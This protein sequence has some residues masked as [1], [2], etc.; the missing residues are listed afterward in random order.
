MLRI[1]CVEIV[2]F[3]VFGFSSLYSAQAAE[4]LPNVLI[5]YGLEHTAMYPA[6]NDLY[7]YDNSI[8]YWGYF[9]PSKEYSYKSGKFTP[10]GWTS[11]NAVG[12]SDHYTSNTDNW[13][14]NFLNWVSMTHADLIRK[15][16][17]GGKRVS[18]ANSK[19]I[20]IREDVR[21]DHAFRKRYSGADLRNLVPDAFA[22]SE[23]YFVTS[24]TTLTIQN[25]S[26]IALGRGLDVKV[27]VCD[28]TMPEVNC[29]LYPSWRMKPEG[30]VQRYHNKFN[31][32]L[33]SHSFSQMTEGGILRVPLGSVSDEF[34]LKSGQIGSSRGVINFIN[35]VDIS[36]GWSPTAELYYE[37]LRYLKGN[38]AGQEAYC[39][40][41]GMKSE[42]GFDVIGCDSRSMWVD[43]ITDPCQKN[44]ILILTDEYPSK[45]TN[46]LPGSSISPGYVDTPMNF[47]MNIPYN[48][49]VGGVTDQIG[50]LEGITGGGYAIGNIVGYADNKCT[51]K[52]I[53][54]LSEAYGICPSEPVA[55]GSF[56]TAALAFD[57][58][59]G[60]IRPDL[61]GRQNAETYVIAYRGSP[62]GY[63]YPIPPLNPLWLTGKYGNFR[64]LDY[65]LVPDDNNEWMKAAEACNPDDPTDFYC[66]PRGL[67]YA[68]RGSAIEDAIVPF[69]RRDIGEDGICDNVGDSDNDGVVDQDDRCPFDPL[70]DTDGDSMCA[71]IDPC[72]NDSANDAD[73][74]GICGDVDVCPDFNDTIDADADGIPDACDNCPNHYNP[75]QEDVNSDGVGDVCAV[76]AQ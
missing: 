17:T 67:F 38:E 13:S 10:E 45:D 54:N 69:L 7:N 21:P 44:I 42:S 65:N 50:L 52:M 29:T 53:I 70:N 73:Q 49:D 46:T 16:M 4:P 58:F 68:E 74:D 63:Q 27:T 1:L 18:D 60:D 37:A 24:G 31:F 11:L 47:G 41:V 75:A 61:P 57:A 26:G 59:T 32:G 36:R 39:G 35:E 19:T 5:L 48:P 55:E 20:L 76:I 9:D 72:P 14:G 3:I 33:M 64:N 8:D 23:N 28:P 30:L 2:L 51:S 12:V 62:S 71:D 25:S 40:A 66:S 43:P 6:Y 56:Y 22:G 15:S 34:S